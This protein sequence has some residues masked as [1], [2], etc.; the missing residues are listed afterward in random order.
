MQ[1]LNKAIEKWKRE[2]GGKEGDSKG[3][4]KSEGDDS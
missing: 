1:Q 2:K 4:G 3:K